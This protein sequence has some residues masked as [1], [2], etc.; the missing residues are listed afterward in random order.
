M[1]K[2]FQTGMATFIFKFGVLAVYEIKLKNGTIVT[3]T[4]DPIR[5]TGAIRDNYWLNENS[6]EKIP[7]EEVEGWRPAF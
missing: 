4:L 2:S 1:E 5:C 7:M 6:K 3:A